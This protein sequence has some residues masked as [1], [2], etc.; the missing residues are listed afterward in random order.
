MESIT[1]IWAGEQDLK[2][3]SD[4][5]WSA[6][7][8]ANAKDPKLFRNSDRIVWIVTDDEHSVMRDVNDSKLRHYMVQIIWF[9]KID[10]GVRINARPPRDLP[11]DI[12]ARPDKF[13]P[14][15]PERDCRLSA[16]RP[17]R[18]TTGEIR[19]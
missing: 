2:S 9:Y 13:G 6:I 15:K 14:A 1:D 4:E 7:V 5:T 16:L 19:L 11:E 18:E 3:I 10:E 8:R 12:L 17:Q